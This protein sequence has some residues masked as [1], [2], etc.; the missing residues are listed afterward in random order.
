M[1]CQRTAPFKTK[2]NH[3]VNHDKLVKGLMAKM[4]G[5]NQV[6]DAEINVEGVVPERQRAASEEIGWYLQLL[7]T[8]TRELQADIWVRKVVVAKN[9]NAT[10][11]ELSSVHKAYGIAYKAQRRAVRAIGKIIEHI[12]NERISFSLV[13]DGEVFG[14][15]EERGKAFR[16]EKFLHELLHTVLDSVRF[17]RVGAE[18]FYPDEKTVEGVCLSLALVSRNEY[19]VDRIVDRLCPNILIDDDHQPVQLAKLYLAEGVDF[20]ATLSELMEKMPDFVSQN[21]RDFKLWHMTID[22]LWPHMCEFVDELLTVFAHYAAAYDRQEGWLQILAD[23][24]QT[25]AYR[26]FLSGHIEAIHSEWQRWFDEPK[27]DEAR[28]LEAMGNE[29]RGIFRRC[30]LT[31]ANVSSGIYVR[32]DFV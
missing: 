13:F 31:L 10:V 28:S 23:I 26:S 8:V 12:E 3:I 14:S 25:P 2:L 11:S 16:F 1:E 22:S 4:N 19:I 9:F 30:G 15:W 6:H 21:I 17:E 24:S 20:R 32:V 29:I 27:S 7:S 18:N 5:D